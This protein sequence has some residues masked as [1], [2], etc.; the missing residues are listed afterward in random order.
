MTDPAR[1]ARLW[2][3]LAVATLWTVS[4]GGVAEVACPASG[5]ETLPAAHIARRR[6]RQRPPARLLSCFRRGRL[7]ILATLL[8]GAPLPLGRFLPEPWPA[9]P[10]P[11]VAAGRLVRTTSCKTYP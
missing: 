4:V 9:T 8:T 10:T 6:G 1:V 2:L 3:A 5:F 7:A 11:S